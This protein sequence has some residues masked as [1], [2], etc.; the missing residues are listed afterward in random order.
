MSSEPR[1]CLQSVLM[2][3]TQLGSIQSIAANSFEQDGL[4]P[5][6]TPTI[7]AGT[8]ARARGNSMFRC[9]SIL[10]SSNLM[11]L[12]HTLQS[13]HSA[14]RVS[15]FNTQII[16]ASRSASSS[17]LVIAA[18]EIWHLVKRTMY[19]TSHQSDSQHSSLSTH[20]SNYGKSCCH[21]PTRERRRRTT[22]ILPSSR[23]SFL[24]TL[25][26]GN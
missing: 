12:A 13:T 17:T 18:S 3:S 14:K 4:G 24:L 8:L 25:P 16:H 10:D 6:A 15:S 22:G 26:P 7:F 11:I 9:L 1:V 19:N 5:S 23:I 21:R 2:F 20:L